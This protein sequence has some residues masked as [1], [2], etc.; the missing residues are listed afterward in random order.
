ML[1]FWFGEAG[2]F[3][4]CIHILYNPCCLERRFVDE[5]ATPKADSDVDELEFDHD[6]HNLVK[7]SK[8]EQAD[9]KKDN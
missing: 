2:L 3:V 5:R 1:A 7:V 4:T 9:A 8:E 6:V